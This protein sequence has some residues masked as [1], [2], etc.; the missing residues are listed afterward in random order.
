MALLSCKCLLSIKYIFFKIQDF[1]NKRFMQSHQSGLFPQ[2][3]LLSSL[4]IFFSIFLMIHILSHCLSQ[5]NS[6]LALS[7]LSTQSPFRKTPFGPTSIWKCLRDHLAQVHWLSIDKN[8]SGQEEP[9]WVRKGNLV[10]VTS[11]NL[12]TQFVRVGLL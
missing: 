10:T 7:A 2:I 9:F 12:K 4:S 5:I 11:H 6:F 1:L 8:S 3:R